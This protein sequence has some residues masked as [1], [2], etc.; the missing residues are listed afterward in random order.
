LSSRR[1]L[2]P[3]V[4]ALLALTLA[5]C[6]ADGDEPAAAGSGAT[7]RATGAAFPVTVEH[8]HGSTRIEAEPKR[9]VTVGFTDHETLLALGIRPVGATDWFGERPYG[10]WRWESEKWGSEKPEIVN[11]GGAE[12]NLEKIAAMRPDLIVG[13]Y[14]DLDASTYG[15]LSQIAP[16]VAQ[17][18][19]A[20]P[21]TTPWRDM[22]RTIG[23]AVGRLD[24][25]DRQIAA[26][27]ERFAQIREEHPEFAEQTAVV[28]DATQAPKSYWAFN[29]ADPRG[30]FLTS[31]GFKADPALEKATSAEFGATI[32]PE[33]ISLLDVGRL[34]LLADP[35]N[36]R[37]LDGQRIFTRLRVVKE[38]RDVRLR[39]Y[40]EPSV[41]GAMA[42][43]TILSIPF[44]IDGLMKELAAKR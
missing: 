37:A 4:L 33:R 16:T 7:A 24:E 5:A 27:D 30:Q 14:A 35:K 1:L 43:S 17:A 6:G 39:Y 29:S 42:F 28:V 19:S 32:S 22:A 18:R 2:V 8:A 12:I 26:I 25:V 11:P 10:K 13:T 38:R 31:L 34:I 23:K 15:K 44:A 41:G 40:E 3:L 9:I 21:Y 20:R 36:S